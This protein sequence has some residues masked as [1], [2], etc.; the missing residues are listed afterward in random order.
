MPPFLRSG[1]AH[2]GASS[3]P[4]STVLPAASPA[5][6]SPPR[7]HLAFLDGLRAVAALL[8]VAC[9]CHLLEVYLHHPPPAGILTDLFD[10]GV[11]WVNTFIVLSGFC[12]M[13]PVARSGVL[14]G[15]WLSF[16]KSRARRI[17]PPLYAVM[18]LA[19]IKTLLRDHHISLE[20]VLV[21]GFLLQDFVQ[22]KPILD[23]PLW[24]VALEWKIYF[25]FPPLIW[26][27]VRYGLR[28]ALTAA[29]AISAALFLLFSASH[30]L[31]N[32]QWA[33]CWYVFLFALGMA[34]AD[35]SHRNAAS[36]LMQRFGLIALG[37]A[38]ALVW[39]QMYLW[40][41]SSGGLL[42]SLHTPVND[43]TEGLSVSIL[44]FLLTRISVAKEKFQL[45]APIF[46]VLSWRPLV[47]I[48]TFSYSIYLLHLILIYAVRDF[49]TAHLHRPVS[50]GLWL[51]DIV[52]VLCASY[53]F[54][55]AFERPFMT[56]PG[57]K[58]KTEAQAEV[59]AIVNPAP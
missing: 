38:L 18:A 41:A 22:A 54:H 46:A 12:L 3:L 28:G 53:S 58:I 17:L 30:G 55:L 37:S 43:I 14:R 40:P 2:A 50:V 48:G 39:L 36:A 59:A 5:S 47:F 13:L 56:K 20:V 19:I 49:L 35:F 51:I 45:L 52:I 42:N 32:M 4:S 31:V 26:L 34:S 6:G 1:L 29:A 33:K 16:Y 23:A 8:V 10:S 9:H 15:G 44:L 21:N 7:L 25:L 24:T 57:V 11:V 27:W